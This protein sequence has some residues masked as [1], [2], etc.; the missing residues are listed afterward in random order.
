MKSEDLLKKRNIWFNVIRLTD[1][2]LTVQDVIKIDFIFRQAR[3]AD[4]PRIKDIA[5]KGWLFAYRHLPKEELTTL[6]NKYY[7]KKNL[8]NS[9]HRVRKGTD[10]FV[11]VE[12]KGQIIGFCQVTAKWGTGEMLRLYIDTAY[13]GKGVGKR[14]L[15][16]SEKFLKSKNCKK[17][18]TFVN[19]HNELGINFYLRN[20]FSRV[21]EKDEEDDFKR[22]KALWYMEKKLKTVK[23]KDQHDKF[24]HHIQKNKMKELWDNKDDEAWEHA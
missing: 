24:L 17:Y 12:L 1:K 18:F 22:G 10:S 5:L 4:F 2:A 21:Q 14:L 20:G 16:E 13:I 6:V 15:L 8:R 23:S 3:E 9:M 7:S 19:K 11:V